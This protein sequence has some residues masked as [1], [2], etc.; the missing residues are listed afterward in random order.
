MNLKVTS[1]KKLLS[2][3]YLLFLVYGLHYLGRQ[4]LPTKITTKEI[5]DTENGMELK[6]RPLPPVPAD[7]DFNLERS[8]SLPAR[9][10]VG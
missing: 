7:A 3:K 9:T 6:V 2:A 10:K 8:K 1:R 5:E 4:S